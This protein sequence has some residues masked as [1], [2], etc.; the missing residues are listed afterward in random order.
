MYLIVTTV[1]SLVEHLIGKSAE[2][3]VVQ[4]AE[5]MVVYM[6]GKKVDP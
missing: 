5:K 4:K 3:K 1:E 2:L 6:L